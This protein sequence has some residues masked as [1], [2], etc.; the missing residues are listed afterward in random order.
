MDSG[1]GKDQNKEGV[2]GKLYAQDIT[3][4]DICTILPT[5]WYGTIQTAELTGKDI[6][7]LCEDGYDAA[8]TGNTYPYVLV[9][10]KELEDNETYQVAIC[11]ADENLALNDSGVVGMDAAKDYFSKFKTLSEADVK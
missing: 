9:K 1:N 3:E 10:N 8:G 5:S 4:A 7:K 6:K 11:G 2:N